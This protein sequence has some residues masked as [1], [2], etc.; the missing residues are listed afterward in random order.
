MCTCLPW[1]EAEEGGL[2]ITTQ[3]PHSWPHALGG[4][5]NDAEEA[6]ARLTQSAL[7]PKVPCLTE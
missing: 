5:G 1:Q 6:M 2:G 7:G 3:L 4:L